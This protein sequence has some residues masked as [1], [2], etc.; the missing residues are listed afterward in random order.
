MRDLSKPITEVTFI[1]GL[2]ESGLRL[3]TFLQDHVFWRSRADLQRRIENGRVLVDGQPRKKSLR[4]QAGQQV[5]IFVD[6]G[7]AL[8][9]VKADR[10]DLR[11]LL[12]D[13]DL[14]VLDKPPSVL[15][16]PVGGHVTDTLLNILHLHYRTPPNEDPAANPMIVHRLDRDTSGVIVFAKNAEARRRLGIDFEE[17]RI[18]KCYLALVHGEPRDECGTV[19][20]PIGPDPD[21]DN[22]TKMACVPE[23]R[24]SETRWRCLK[25]L[26]GASLIRCDPLTGRQHQIRVHMA[27]IG[28]P[29]LCDALYAKSTQVTELEA[30]LGRLGLHA[31][32]LEF[33]HPTSGE[34]I[35]VQA[36][37]PFDM[38]Q[39]IDAASQPLPPPWT[40]A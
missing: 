34:L 39:V 20:L 11:I 33:C 24:P 38:A 27:A 22:R 12:E 36:P 2:A 37:V 5:L 18:R 16:H 14:V 23:G 8:Q 35:S 6:D 4:L 30:G 1:V 40:D 17:R 32:A 9:P 13:K 7:P 25:R 26:P 15:C 10:V 3:D 19:S 28:H 21:S 31:E 29:L